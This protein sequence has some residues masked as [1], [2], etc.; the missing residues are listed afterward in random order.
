M[1][2]IYSKPHIEIEGYELVSSIAANCDPIV[3]LGPE[4]P[5][6][7]GVA[8]SSYGNDYGP[9]SRSVGTS[10]YDGNMG[11][12]DCYYTSGYEGYFTS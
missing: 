5:E 4:G 9:W 3:N 6:P 11:G 7:G 2:K 1:K 12:C 10:F 8:C